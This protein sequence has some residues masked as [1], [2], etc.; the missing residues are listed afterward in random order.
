MLGAILRVKYPP[1]YYPHIS[2]PKSLSC[3]SYFF[4]KECSQVLRYWHTRIFQQLFTRKNLFPVIIPNKFDNYWF[5]LTF[6]FWFPNS[7]RSINIILCNFFIS[8]LVS[9]TSKAKT[10]VSSFLFSGIPCIN[11]RFLLECCSCLSVSVVIS[12][13]F[14][15]W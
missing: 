2:K 1:V 15:L 5:Q 14:H 6:G 12:S 7:V 11:R 10:S 3:V 9:I 4:H 8:I 13:T